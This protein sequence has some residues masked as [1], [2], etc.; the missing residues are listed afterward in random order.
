MYTS[1]EL[2]KKLKDGGCELEAEKA[3]LIHED[4]THSFIDSENFSKNLGLN[5]AY[6]IL[7]DIC[8]KYAKEFF[9]ELEACDKCLEVSC[10]AGEMFC[11]EYKTAGT[12]TLNWVFFTKHIFNLIQKNKIQEAEDYIW[13]H[14]LFNPKN[15]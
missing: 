4:K 9:G 12:T 11:D 15:K 14:C 10:L 8:V 1:K 6:D 7:N 5:Y 3:Y 13:E 2:S